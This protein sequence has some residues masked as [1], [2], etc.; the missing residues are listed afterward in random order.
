MSPNSIGSVHSRDDMKKDFLDC[1]LDWVCY[2]PFLISHSSNLHEFSVKSKLLQLPA[3]CLRN[4][5]IFQNG[6]DGTQRGSLYWLLNHTVTR[7]GARLLKA[8]LAQPLRDVGYVVLSSYFTVGVACSTSQG[9]WVCGVVMVFCCVCA[10]LSL[11]G[12]LGMWCCHG[13]FTVVVAC[14]TS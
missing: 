9:C 10:L 8:W 2:F 5:E 11:S 14:S 13:V 1:F 12:M 3:A 7:P 4:L 6:T